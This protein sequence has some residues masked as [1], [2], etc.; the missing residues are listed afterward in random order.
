MTPSVIQLTTIAA[1]LIAGI[2]YY[3]ILAR[4]SKNNRLFFRTLW[5]LAFVVFAVHA[6]TDGYILTECTEGPV[7]YFSVAVL[8]A[9]HSLE[10]FVFQSHIF[11]NG[12]Q[13][14]FFGTDALHPGRVWM[15]YLCVILFVLASITSIA[16]VIRAL[17]R[18]RAGRAWLSSHH[19]NHGPSHIFFL[20]GSISWVVAEDIRRRHPDQPCIFIG[21]P[22]PEE[23]YMDL[24]VWEKIKRLFQSLTE[25]GD[26]PFQAVVYSRIPL[27]DVKGPDVCNQLGL[28]DLLYFLNDS[29]C[30]VYLLD[31]S[32]QKNLH[33]TEILYRSGCR[34]EIFCRAC[35]EGVNSMYEEAMTTT[36]QIKVHLVDSS[37]LAVRNIK[38]CPEL[39]PVQFVDKGTDA[40]G[41]CEAWVKSPFHAAI[42]GF[43]ETGREALAFL[44]EHGSFIGQDFQRSGFSCAVY[45]EHMESLEQAYLRRFPG[46][47]AK[48]G[49]EF[50]DYR[51]GGNEFWNDMDKRIADLNYVVICLGDDRLNLRI[52][53]DLAEYAV[54][55]GKNL[56]RNFVI[57]I[58]QQDPT[59]L[60]KVT[61]AHYNTIGRYHECIKPFGTL[62]TVWTY[63]NITN[64]SLEARAKAYYA[65]YSR[66]EGK[67][68]DA[69]ANW[70]KREEEIRLAADY[71]LYAKR[72]RQR[73]QDYANCFHMATK[74]ALMGPEIYDCRKEI[75][76]AIPSDF[77][78]TPVHY[79]GNDPHVEKVLK[80]LAVLEHI[81]WEAS[82]VAL[83]YTPST[84]TN[85]VLKTHACIVSYD[86]LTPLLQHY[87]YLVVKATLDL[88]D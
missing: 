72:V 34:A 68:V 15:L 10:L 33:C 56:A 22:D 3:F 55:S 78:K 43:G 40:E 39:L 16:L 36:P 74:R 82:H 24:S 14:F 8:A 76:Q 21:Y 7:N 64:E 51:V 80:Y 35:R 6:V 12:Y 61:L 49:I 65:G 29:S 28:N 71:E 30:K 70:Q 62:E 48:A 79:T 54:R 86:D 25:S 37:Y 83:G 81:R 67:V 41:R 13:E 63:D 84:V 1:G 42:L 69:E 18:R 46:M 31:D 52:A 23:N 45:D 85:E 60:D 11:D 38:N 5:I 2:C 87:D 17:N 44:Y 57:L 50:L 75:A 27:E 4:A 9:F 53:I 58:S 77:A 66:A 47:N 88:L 59:E 32:E 20:G 73:S 19:S 26:G